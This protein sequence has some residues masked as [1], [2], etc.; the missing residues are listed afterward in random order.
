MKKLLN[1]Y[2]Q[3]FANIQQPIWI[4]SLVMFINRSGAMV[5]LFASLYFIKELD[6]SIAQAGLVMSFYGMGSVLGSFTGGWL[7]DRMNFFDIM[8]FKVKI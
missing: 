7:T 4:L 1:L 3:S 5:L 6:L 2:L 8:V